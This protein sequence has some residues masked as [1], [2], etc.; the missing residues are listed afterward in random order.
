MIRFV[1]RH[2]FASFKL[3]PGLLRSVYLVVMCRDRHSSSPIPLPL[4]VMEMLMKAQTSQHA[5]F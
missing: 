3:N 2:Y 1:N 5:I 4:P